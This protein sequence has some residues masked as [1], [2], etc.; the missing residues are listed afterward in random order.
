M[1]KEKPVN[2]SKCT[3]TKESRKNDKISSRLIICLTGPMAAGK[4]AAGDILQKHGFLSI[5]ADKCVPFSSSTSRNARPS[6]S[7]VVGRSQ[8]FL[9]ESR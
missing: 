7:P 2:F 4:N 8:S 6:S 3:N 5:D 1:E 9:V